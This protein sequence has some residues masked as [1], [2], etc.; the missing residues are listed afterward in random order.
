MQEIA[1]FSLMRVARCD[2]RT[3]S[4]FQPRQRT[5]LVPITDNPDACAVVRRKLQGSSRD[6]DQGAGVPLLCVPDGIAGAVSK[7]QLSGDF[8]LA[9]DQNQGTWAVISIG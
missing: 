6:W 4:N 9:G 2:S 5:L 1:P 3:G 7:Q 8:V